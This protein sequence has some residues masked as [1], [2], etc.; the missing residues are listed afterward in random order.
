MEAAQRSRRR[1]HA[2][3]QPPSHSPPDGQPST[4]ERTDGP[5][6]FPMSGSLPCYAP[7]LSAC[8]WPKREASAPPRRLL[9][10][11]WAVRV[12]GC[13]AGLI[14]D[15]PTSC[16]RSW[17]GSSMGDG[18][19]RCP[20]LRCQACQRQR[21]LRL[22]TLPH[23]TTHSTCSTNITSRHPERLPPCTA[24]SALIHRPLLSILLHVHSVWH[25]AAPRC[26]SS[27]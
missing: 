6:L 24:N 27:R 20:L 3:L 23:I 13:S 8:P 18:C 16:T 15:R 22:A 17:G 21:A 2:C 9:C 11:R 10:W 7:W 5:R 12:S 26:C 1:C 25:G 4:G 19:P 14:D